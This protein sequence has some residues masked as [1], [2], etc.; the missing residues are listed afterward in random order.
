MSGNIQPCPDNAHVLQLRLYLRQRAPHSMEFAKPGEEQLNRYFPPLND[1]QASKIKETVRQ[2][3]AEGICRKGK[4]LFATFSSKRDLTRFVLVRGPQLFGKRIPID[5]PEQKR[6]VSSDGPPKADTNGKTKRHKRPAAKIKKKSYMGPTINRFDD[7]TTFTTNPHAMAELGKFLFGQE[8]YARAAAVLQQATQSSVAL[9]PQI[10]FFKGLSEL[11][12]YGLHNAELPGPAVESLEAAVESLQKF[13]DSVPQNPLGWRALGKALYLLSFEH[14]DEFEKRDLQDT[15]FIAMSHA[16]TLEPTSDIEDKDQIKWGVHAADFLL[17]LGSVASEL[18]YY[19]IAKYYLG[20]LDQF[21]PSFANN[22]SNV[23][24][25]F[26]KLDVKHIQ[27]ETT[28]HDNDKAE[29]LKRLAKVHLAVR[30]GFPK[31]S[32]SEATLGRAIYFLDE[33]QELNPNDF[34]TELTRGLA[35]LRL[36]YYDRANEFFKEAIQ[37]DDGNNIRILEQALITFG[38]KNVN[39]WRHLGTFFYHLSGQRP[40]E[41]KYKEVALNALIKAMSLLADYEDIEAQA[42]NSLGDNAY[43][44][45]LV[46]V[47]TVATELNKL[48][49]ATHYLSQADRLDRIRD[50]SW[51]LMGKIVEPSKTIYPREL[52]ALNKLRYVVIEGDELEESSL[53]MLEAA[54]AS[55]DDFFDTTFGSA[56]LWEQSRPGGGFSSDSSVANRIDT[57]R[58]LLSGSLKTTPETDDSEGST[59]QGTPGATNEPSPSSAP[60]SSSRS[61]SPAPN[62]ST[63]ANDNQPPL[64]VGGFAG[65]EQI[66]QSPGTSSTE[67]AWILYNYETSTLDPDADDI[68]TVM[69]PVG[70]AL[71]LSIQVL[72]EPIHTSL[73]LVP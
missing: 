46:S 34:E 45:L 70:S 32:W 53:D 10:W 63:S 40:E 69:D 11:R 43:E 73:A 33:A 54:D 28:R 52:H 51:H 6:T 50:E 42:A 41:P 16:V 38:F 14:D 3:E 61:T 31:E 18:G 44:E 27:G 68:D 39:A 8:I 57:L 1:R 62:G 9:Q 65:V 15:A 17:E 21:L 2:Y 4:A 49:I 56:V 67:S 35:Y 23:L 60:T 30:D 25:G 58:Q 36:E 29:Y 71:N 47:V 72:V 24:K 19:T 59:G 7:P 66:L 37:L 20:H 55:A 26:L 48:D 13:A 22:A 5:D 12:F 64:S